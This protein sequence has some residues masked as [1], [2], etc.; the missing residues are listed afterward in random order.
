MSLRFSNIILSLVLLT[1]G[2]ASLSQTATRQAAQQPTPANKIDKIERQVSEPYT[3]T[4]DIFED[5]KRDENLQINRVMDALKINQG[6]SVAD[7]GAGSG[8]F[9]LRA[10]R[11]VG[12]SGAVY[13]VEINQDYINH[14]NNRAKAENLPVIKTVLGAEDNPRLPAKAIDAALMLKTYHEIAE[15]VRVLRNLRGSLKAGGRLGVIDRNGNGGDHGIDRDVV[16]R[17]AAQA[18]FKLVE[19]YDFVKPDGMDYFLVF[20]SK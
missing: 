14:I 9:T 4:L 16:V 10:A 5:P 7:I 15:P 1:S 20:E 13:A 17:E 12:A 11:R 19:E 8:W 3:G 2:C 6:K 18:G